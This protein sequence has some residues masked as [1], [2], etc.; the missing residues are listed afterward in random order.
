VAGLPETGQSRNQASASRTRSA[1]AT[2]ASGAIVLMSA[3]T[4]P[5]RRPASTPSGPS[6]VAWIAAVL[7][8][9]V[10]RTST[11]PAS[12]RG[13]SA[14]PMPASSSGCAFP[15]VRFQPMTS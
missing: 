8:S 11:R 1:S 14:Q 13:V 9:M 4:V 5:G 3:H 2:L 10:N 15:L 12:S 6:A 7:V